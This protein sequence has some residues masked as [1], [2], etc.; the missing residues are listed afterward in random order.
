MMEKPSILENIILAKEKYLDNQKQITPI[1][2]LIRDI[3]QNNIPKNFSGSLMG[4]SV[5]LI[6]EMKKASPSKGIIS[7]KYD[8]KEI[9]LKYSEANVAAISILT[10][11]DFFQGDIS[12]LSDVSSLLKTTSIPIFRKDFI[13]DE[14]QIY[15]SRKHGAD[16]LLLMVS[17]LDPLKLKELI[18]LCK[19]VQKNDGVYITHLRDVNTERGFGGG[20]VPEALEIGRKS[21]VKVHFSHTRTSAENAGKVSEVLE[22]IDKA[23]SEGVECTL[24]L[25]PYP[26]GSS[27]LLS[28][29]PSWAHEGGPDDILKRLN[30]LDS[31]KKIIESLKN[32]TKRQMESVL[33]SYLPNNPELEGMTVAELSEIRNISMG[34]LICDLLIEQDLQV[35]FWQVPPQSISTWRQISKDAM[36]F[37]S[38]EDYMIGSD[39]I[40]I[41]SVP[42]P[43]AY[44]TFPRFIGRLRRQFK[45]ISLEKMIQRVSNNPANTF[46]LSKRGLIKNGNFADIVIFDE[47]KMI[48]TATYDDPKQYPL[49]I[50]YVVVNGIVAVDKEVCTGRFAGYAVP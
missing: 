30:D 21:G 5:M 23:K 50:P 16:S 26:T 10:D 35:G 17:V 19:V 40:H 27:F 3:E 4:D 22:L 14:Y 28:S 15:E 2:L 29:L 39:S 33:L 6:A 46:N 8:P 13:I 7:E 34:D 49:G 32:N 36:D 12:H 42:H 1:E 20:G 37:I 25:Y 43:R 45:V 47:D 38:R 31:R 18:E 41:G 48:D 44:G 11:I 24:E 9:A